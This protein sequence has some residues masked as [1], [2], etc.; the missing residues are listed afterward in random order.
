VPKTRDQ[1][2]AD[3]RAHIAQGGGGYSKWYVGITKD[4]DSRL[5]NHHG[6]KKSG[7]WWIYREAYS[8]E[9]ARAVEDYFVNRCGTDGDVGGGDDEST[10]VYAYKK[11]AHT[12][13]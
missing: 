1:I 11:A 5:F 6:V 7:D 10:F 8:S 9:S 3:I 13:P 4:V 12:D 2:I